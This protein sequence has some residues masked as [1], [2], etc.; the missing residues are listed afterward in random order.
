MKENQMFEF[1]GNLAEEMKEVE[2][3]YSSV[4]DIERGRT[5]TYECTGL[6]TIVCC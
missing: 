5:F 3:V 2:K 4:E 1:A 6:L